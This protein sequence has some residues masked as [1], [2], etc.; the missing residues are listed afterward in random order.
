M[1]SETG[2]WQVDFDSPRPIYLQIVDEVK[3]A[4]ARQAL[5]PG[6]RIPSQ[7]DLAQT[8]RVNPNKVQRAFREMEALGLVETVRGEGTF[9]R[10]DP[11][12]LQMLRTEMARAAVRD[13]V[14][15]VR[16]LG[17]DEEEVVALVRA[18]FRG[19]EMTAWP[20]DPV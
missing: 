20:S 12:L 6:D 15:E 17:M 18:A 5:R 14:R 4:V 2:G 10:N 9:V 11:R 7:R 3:R 1:A 19:E 16:A 8:L 13:F